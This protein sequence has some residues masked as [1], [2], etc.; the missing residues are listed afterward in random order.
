MT[1]GGKCYE[2]KQG[3]E[4]YTQAALK[5]GK[6]QGL[7]QSAIQNVYFCPQVWEMTWIVEKADS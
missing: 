4:N 1:G 6:Q 2:I 7:G 3:R 5:V